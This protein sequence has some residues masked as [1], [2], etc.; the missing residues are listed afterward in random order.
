M[1]DSSNIINYWLKST[2][3]GIAIINQCRIKTYIIL[4]NLKRDVN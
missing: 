2:L 4:I 1:C 3:I